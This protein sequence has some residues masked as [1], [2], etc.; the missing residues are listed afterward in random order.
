MVEAL[1]AS[2]L[3]YALVPSG[4]ALVPTYQHIGVLT[5]LPTA[6]Q[7]H[8]ITQIREETQHL[9]DCSKLE[10][11]MT[12]KGVLAEKACSGLSSR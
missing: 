3:G 8:L 12:E 10:R 4:L 11:Q 9:A 5:M 7:W 1:P 2:R 6:I